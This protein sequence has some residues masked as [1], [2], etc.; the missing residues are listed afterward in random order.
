MIGPGANSPAGE[1]QARFPGKTILYHQNSL[2]RPVP[3]D[4]EALVVTIQRASPGRLSLAVRPHGLL[5]RLGDSARLQRGAKV[6][7]SWAG[8]AH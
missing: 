1:I 6:A 2:V 8:G 5:L 7:S 3:A 4:T